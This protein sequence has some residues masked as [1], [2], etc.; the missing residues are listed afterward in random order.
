MKKA[1]LIMAHGSRAEAA[2]REF[3][4]LVETVAEAAH[5]YA[6]VLPCFLELARPSLQEALQQLEHQPVDAVYVYPL[7]FNNGK[8]VSTDIPAQVREARERHPHL[9]IELL[10]YFGNA[11]GLAALVGE[12]IRAQIAAGQ[13]D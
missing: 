1:L 4:A 7:F 10:D 6:A 11:S 12:H 2:N 5:D 9:S 3:E 13:A 8:H